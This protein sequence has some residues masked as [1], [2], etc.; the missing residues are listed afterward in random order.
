VVEQIAPKHPELPRAR[1]WLA[2]MDGRC[3]DAMRYA[4]AFGGALLGSA[5][6]MMRDFAS[7]KELFDPAAEHHAA[8]RVMRGACRLFTGDVAG[9]TEDFRDVYYA[10]SAT[11]GDGSLGV[12][13]YALGLYIYTLAKAGD[14]KTATRYVRELQTAA[15]RRYVSPM[16]LAVAHLGLG[17]AETAIEF[18]QDAMRRFDP[19][20]AYVRVDPMLDE[21]REHPEFSSLARNAA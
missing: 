1:V 21:L 2:L 19:W 16:A 4:R 9:A 3:D 5:L 20:A 17:D 14:R 18:V 12:R 7:A 6:Y 15:R 10:D 11:L 8:S 13:H